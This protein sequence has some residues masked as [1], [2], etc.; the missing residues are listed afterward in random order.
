MQFTQLYGERR[1]QS[2]VGA[3]LLLSV[4]AQQPDECELLFLLAY[5]G[6]ASG[7]IH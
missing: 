4:H 5:S 1:A 7:G 6:S 2:S 3:C